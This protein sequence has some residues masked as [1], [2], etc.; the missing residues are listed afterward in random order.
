MRKLLSIIWGIA[1]FCAEKFW[2]N[3]ANWYKTIWGI[4]TGER[5][6]GEI[7]VKRK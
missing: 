5:I 6:V 1:T 3:V 4:A 7:L 2:G